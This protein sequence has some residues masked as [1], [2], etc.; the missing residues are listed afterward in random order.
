MG[1]ETKTVAISSSEA[2]YVTAAH[3]CQELIWLRQLLA[4]MG[5]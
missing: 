3:A 5:I 1:K 4:D 2:E